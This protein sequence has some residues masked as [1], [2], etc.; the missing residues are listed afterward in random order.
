LNGVRRKLFS[1][2]SF[3]AEDVMGRPLEKWRRGM[4]LILYISVMPD[5]VHLIVG[6]SP[7][8]SETLPILKVP[9]EPGRFYRSWRTYWG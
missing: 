2:T 6:Y 1:E 7:P 8:L 5:H 3:Y 4:G 9:L